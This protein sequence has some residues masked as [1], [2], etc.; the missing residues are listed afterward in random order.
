MRVRPAVMWVCVRV[1]H[2][3]IHVNKVNSLFTEI[4]FS[5]RI[6]WDLGVWPSHNL[7]FAH[8][9]MNETVFV[10]NIFRCCCAVDIGAVLVSYMKYDCISSNGCLRIGIYLSTRWEWIEREGAKWRQPKIM[11]RVLSV[12]YFIIYIRRTRQIFFLHR[13]HWMSRSQLHVGHEVSFINS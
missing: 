5:T 12:E 9:Q 3:A 6:Q 11:M 1:S 7:Q 10:S 13:Q 2:T 8:R 4:E